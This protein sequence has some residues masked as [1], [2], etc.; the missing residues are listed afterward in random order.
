MPKCNV[1]RCAIDACLAARNYLHDYSVVAGVSPA[2][3][4]C[5]VASRNDVRALDHQDHGSFRRAGAVAH[6]FGNDEALSR[7][8]IDNAIFKIHPEI[9]LEDEKTF[10]Q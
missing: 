7:C 6:T 9:S 4:A 3:S 2:F 5:S 10:V 1:E 8:E